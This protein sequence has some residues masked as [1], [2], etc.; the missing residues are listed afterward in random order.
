MRRSTTARRKP[1]GSPH[2]PL[3]PGRVLGID[4]G[5]RWIGFALLDQGVPRYWGTIDLRDHSRWRH[6]PMT[7]DEVLPRVRDHIGTMLADLQPATVVLEAPFT[8]KTK[9]HRVVHVVLAEI[10]RLVDAS[11]AK[12]VAIAPSTARAAV[13]GDGWAT[14]E[15]VAQ[16]L[17]Q[18]FPELRSWLTPRKTAQ[19]ARY[20]HH[21]ADALCVAFAVARGV[22]TPPV[23]PYGRTHKTDLSLTLAH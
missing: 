1:D 19:I 21:S 5:A 10:E 16:T 6:E 4:G 11:G 9:R 3:V 15:Q 18:R 13:V 22:R 17:A 12:R 8:L 2:R 14:K 20:A 23:R 7:A